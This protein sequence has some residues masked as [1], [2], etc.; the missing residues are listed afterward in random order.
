MRHSLVQQSDNAIDFVGSRIPPETEADRAHA[1]LLR[2]AR[3]RKDF[4]WPE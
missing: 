1:D 2:N 4:T 3:S